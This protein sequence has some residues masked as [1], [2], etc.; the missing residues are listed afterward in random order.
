MRD[1]L[2]IADKLG[3]LLKDRHETI[4]IAE[5]STGG[6]ISA[7]LVAVPGASAYFLG[8][9]VVYTRQ[10]RLLLLDIPDAALDEPIQQAGREPVQKQDPPGFEPQRGLRPVPPHRF[11]DGASHFFGLSLP[12]AGKS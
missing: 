9:G 11:Q 3:A 12:S 7:A 5:S 8:G 1:L 2:P 10:S 4:A 6:L